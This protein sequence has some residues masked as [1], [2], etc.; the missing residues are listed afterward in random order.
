MK[1]LNLKNKGGLLVPIIIFSSVALVVI[2][3]IIKWTQITIEANRQL[4]TREKAIQLAES[5]IDYY[6]WHLAHS[7]SDYQDGTG[8]PGPYVHE[9]RDKDGNVVGEFV[10]DITPPIIGSTKVRIES[11]GTLA[12]STISRKI[13]VEMAIPSLAKYA[14]AANDVMR[15]GEGTEVFGPVHSNQGIHF[16]GLAHNIIT[17]SLALY[18][19]PDHEN[20][21]EF[22]VH[23]HVNIPPDSGINEN[24]RPLEA[25]PNSVMSRTDVFEVGRQ[26]PVPVIDFVGLTGNLANIKSDAQA[27][28]HYF[29]ASG[30]QGYHLVL[31]TDDTFDVYVVN[32][33]EPTPN[34]CTLVIG[35]Q[36]WGTWS[37]R[38]VGGE[39]FLGNYGFP[40]NGL[41]FVEDN[42]WVNG[43]INGARLTIAAGRFP[44]NP[45]QRKS[46]TVNN[47]LL[48]TNYDGTDVLA[49][50]AQ[51]NINA[52]L[53]SEN[54]LRID[55]AMIAQ[56]GRVGRY[57]Y[58]PPTGGNDRCSPYHLR[59]EI[60]L[61]GMI[62][63]Y[64][65]YGFSYNDGTGY[66]IRNII[67]DANLLYSPPPSFPL[68][69]DQYEILSWEEI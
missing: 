34:G 58:R 40:S 29:A 53:V 47:D 25:S 20:N 50:V 57:Y 3:S 64:Q 59:N 45:A 24:F 66:Q 31:K 33:L 15:F 23:T 8:L 11:T 55:A 49:L 38:S 63:T 60:T 32:N 41:I 12:S 4:I 67:Y 13:R 61:Y 68:T 39:V 6:R 16:D 30:S 54:D 18:N 36:G 17:S 44:D 35:Q 14:V 2:G 51:N 26:F 37:I 1:N 43:Q 42:V 65:R 10:L 22:G 5:G 48:Y 19:D 62:A 9:V 52:G 28:G 27:N 46:I 7:Q 56:N 21:D 69:S